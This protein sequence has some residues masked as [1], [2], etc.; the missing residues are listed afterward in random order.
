MK[1][2]SEETRNSEQYIF[3]Y[4][5]PMFVEIGKEQKKIEGT[6]QI[7]DILYVTYTIE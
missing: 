2:E 6:N 3:L 1:M 4:H 7:R 5:L